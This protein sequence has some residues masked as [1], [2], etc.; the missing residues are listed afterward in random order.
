VE[1][2]CE[3]ANE[4]SG[5][6]KCGNFLSNFS[7]R[8]LLHG[9]TQMDLR[10]QT[11]LACSGDTSRSPSGFRASGFLVLGFCFDAL[12]EVKS[13]CNLVSAPKSFDGFFFLWSAFTNCYR[14]PSV[15]SNS[16]PY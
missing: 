3:C 1:G 2:S 7:G 9:V 13:V 4:S 8:T 5:S 15:L 10:L 12:L 16:Q 14:K 6:I 11:L